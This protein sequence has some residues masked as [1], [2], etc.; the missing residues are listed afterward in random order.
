MGK[1]KGTSLICDDGLASGGSLPPRRG[2]GVR[3][4]PAELGRDGSEL[5]LSRTES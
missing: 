2:S 1:E 5:M 4:P 3:S